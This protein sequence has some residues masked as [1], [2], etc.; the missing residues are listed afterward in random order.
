MLAAGDVH[1]V[2]QKREAAD[3]VMPSKLTNILAAGR[4]SVAT[5]DPGTTLYEVLNEHDCGI[6]TAPGDVEE[7]VRAVEKLADDAPERA[8]LG[9]NA[10]RYAEVC[11][12]RERILS[13]FERQLHE[14]VKPPGLPDLPSVPPSAG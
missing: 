2:V 6:T 4:A 11:L 13:E 9:R 1:L 10:R 3:L 14:L 12:D 5:A 7:L 8:R